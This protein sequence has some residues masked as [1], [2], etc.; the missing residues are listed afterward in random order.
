MISG[1]CCLSS[2]PCEVCGALSICPVV[3]MVCETET[4]RFI[5]DGEKGG[6][7]YGGGGGGGGGGSSAYQTNALPLGQTDSLCPIACCCH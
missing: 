1:L 6:R 3:N 2:Y 5:R 4:I 7:G